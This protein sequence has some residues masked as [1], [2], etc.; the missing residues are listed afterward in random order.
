ML[1]K[2]GGL[3]VRCARHLSSGPESPASAQPPASPASAQTPR[4]GCEA[5]AGGS[6]QWG[7][8]IRRRILAFLF[9]HPNLSKGMAACLRK[10]TIFPPSRGLGS[11]APF[12]RDSAPPPALLPRLSWAPR[13]TSPH[14]VLSGP[15]GPGGPAAQDASLPSR[16]HICR[17][18]HF[19]EVSRPAPTSSVCVGG[20]AGGS[21]YVVI[22][23]KTGEFY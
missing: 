20:R 22:S 17:I 12:S 18:P 3:S 13:L 10:A 5:L 14:A 9:G 1:G 7:T 6:P 15:R 23:L 16:L 19:S 8:D 2:R 4:C 21:V 11:F